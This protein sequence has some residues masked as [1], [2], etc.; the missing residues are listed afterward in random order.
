MTLKKFLECGRNNSTVFLTGCLDIQYS[1]TLCLLD[2]IWTM[3]LW[4]HN[5]LHCC[6]TIFSFQVCMCIHL[7]IIC[8]ILCSFT[9]QC[10]EC[11]L[12]NSTQCCSYR[13][14]NCKITTLSPSE[15]PQL[16]DASHI[17][18]PSNAQHGS[19]MTL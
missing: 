7:H 12:F 2:V 4:L 3:L 18:T 19:K 14:Q 8:Y 16:S 11:T 15:T 9:P 13:V 10:V 5:H 6:I 1:L 17:H